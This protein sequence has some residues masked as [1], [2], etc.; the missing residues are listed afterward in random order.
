MDMLQEVINTNEELGRQIEK[1]D[2]KMQQGWRKYWWCTDTLKELSTLL[3]SPNEHGY[4]LT[5]KRHGDIEYLY[6]FVGP[7]SCESFEEGNEY[8]ELRVWETSYDE[9]HD[10]LYKTFKITQS[11][12]VNHVSKI[13]EAAQYD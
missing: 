3:T 8:I 4:E 10:Q 12:I 9:T 2:D 1:C 6:E 13:K 5:A 11:Q 7:T